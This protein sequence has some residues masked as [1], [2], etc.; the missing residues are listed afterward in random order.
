[1][2]QS[3]VD[4]AASSDHPN[5]AQNGRDAGNPEDHALNRGHIPSLC[6]SA[7]PG[8]LRLG[9]K[10]LEVARRLEE[11]VL[12]IDQRGSRVIRKV[13]DGLERDGAGRARFLAEPA[14]DTAQHVDLVDAG[15]SLPGRH[16][17]VRRILG[18]LDVDA[19][20]GTGARAEITADASLESVLVAMK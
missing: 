12:G 1:E 4:S 13:E 16:P 6:W 9:R 8:R 14:E 18:R 2:G 15:V 20:G 17:S 11:H 3:A 7:V 19:V 5:P 10:A